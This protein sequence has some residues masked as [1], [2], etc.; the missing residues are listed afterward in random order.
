MT[1]RV[2]TNWTEPEKAWLACAIDSEG[3]VNLRRDSRHVDTMNLSVW[4][5]N[6]NSEF[7]QRFADLSGGAIYSRG[8]R[9]FG[10][11]DLYEV[12]VTSKG[13]I[14]RILHATLP[15]LIVKREKAIQVLDW[16]DKHPESRNE[17]M[18]RLNKILPR[19][20]RGSNSTSTRYTSLTRQNPRCGL[21]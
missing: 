18:I 15:Y 8:P 13:R 1:S 17:N 21:Q 5:Y 2:V 9:A 6:T 11:K 10:K 14:A 4:F 7:A 19:D 16:I 12:Y 3:S 20:K